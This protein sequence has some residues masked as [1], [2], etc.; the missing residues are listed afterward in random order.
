MSRQSQTE[1]TRLFDNSVRQCVRYVFCRE[2]DKIPIKRSEILEQIAPEYRKK[3]KNVLVEVE[4]ELKRVYGY[5]L[6]EIKD[7]DKILYIV[8]LDEA[9]ESPPSRTT[10]L[11][12]KRILSGALTHIFMSGRPVK[13]DD[14]WS[15]L[16][17]SGLLAE[18]NISGRKLL[19]QQFT[20]QLYL[21]YSKMGEGELARYT[22]DWGPRANHEL[23]KKF[24]LQ[25]VAVAFGTDPACWSEQYK[26]TL[27]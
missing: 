24:I 16:D 15:F 20:K 7:K 4:K 13:E 12:Q 8:V 22:F 21:S 26:R 11:L 23:P 27:Q 9:C 14:M 5:K 10:D 2:A 18:D 25:K 3:S 1:S 6:V 19:T 17:K